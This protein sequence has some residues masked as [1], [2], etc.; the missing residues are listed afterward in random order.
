MQET[1]TSVRLGRRKQFLAFEL[2][3]KPWFLV[4]EIGMRFRV[5]DFANKRERKR[6][7]KRH[8]FADDDDL[9][10]QEELWVLR[11][12]S[13]GHPIAR[14]RPIAVPEACFRRRLQRRRAFQRRT[15]RAAEPG[16]SIPQM[17]TT[18]RVL[19]TGDGIGRA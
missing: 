1:P 10:G 15:S 7:R 11:Y 2:V 12:L 18:H 5:L 4:F 9:R 17:S 13:T 14:R 6:T 8:L 3:L 19:R 16:R